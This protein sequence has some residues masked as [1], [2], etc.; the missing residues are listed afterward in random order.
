MERSTDPRPYRVKCQALH[1]GRLAFELGQHG[2]RCLIVRQRDEALALQSLHHTTR[3]IVEFDLHDLNDQV[4]QA[5]RNNNVG[6]MMMKLAKYDV[7]ATW[8]L[9][10]S[11]ANTTFDTIDDNR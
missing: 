11:C 7:N 4:D 5:I 8:R 3:V 1:P 6:K 9:L 10:A 2:Q